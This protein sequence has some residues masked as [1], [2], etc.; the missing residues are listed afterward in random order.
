MVLVPRF[1]NSVRQTAIYTKNDE[2]LD[3]H[4]CRIGD[5]DIDV[6]ISA[7]HVGMVFRSL[8]YSVVAHR[9]AGE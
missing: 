4:V 2:I 1:L 3:W 9:L 5:P 6:E 8:V 7:T